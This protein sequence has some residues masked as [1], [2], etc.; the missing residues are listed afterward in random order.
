[1]Q[2]VW[3]LQGKAQPTADGRGYIPGGDSCLLKGQA[4]SLVLMK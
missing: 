2:R 4:N 1:M 3:E